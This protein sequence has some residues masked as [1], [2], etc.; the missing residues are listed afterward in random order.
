M[1]GPILSIRERKFLECLQ[2]HKVRF[3]IVG[4]TSAVLQGAHVVTQDIDL[5]INDLGNAQFLAAVKEA[6]GIYVPPEV[7]GMNPPMLGPSELKIF[8][9]ISHMHG[10]EEFD[11]EYKHSIEVEV[12]GLHLKILPLERIITSKERANLEK[13]QAV[14][15]T[16]KAALLMKTK[17]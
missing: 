9:L 11:E 16:L 1:A 12:S 7:V 15:P 8:D 14:L 4:L 5:W 10:L 6:G 13:D 2:Q 17:L 3:M